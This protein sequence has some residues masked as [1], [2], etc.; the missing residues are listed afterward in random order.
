MHRSYSISLYS[1]LGL[2]K[3]IREFVSYSCVSSILHSVV[4]SLHLLPHCLII[5]FP[6]LH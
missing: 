3:H 4:C 6:S 1:V 5:F 2:F